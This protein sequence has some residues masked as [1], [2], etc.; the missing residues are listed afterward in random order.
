MVLR[1]G[2]PSFYVNTDATHLFANNTSCTLHR[3]FL[4]S[5]FLVM[6]ITISKIKCHFGPDA[7]L[8][9]LM[10]VLKG[11]II[12][13]WRKIFLSATMRTWS[14]LVSHIVKRESRERDSRTHAWSQKDQSAGAGTGK[15]STMAMETLSLADTSLNHW[16]RKPYIEHV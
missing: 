4:M 14:L 15:I 2:E 16:W 11:W 7:F 13:Y 1:T 3:R 6:A 10:I 9:S 5:K 8:A 12:G